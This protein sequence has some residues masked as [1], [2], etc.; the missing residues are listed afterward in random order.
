[1]RGKHDYK[2]TSSV[3]AGFVRRQGVY[4]LFVAF[5]SISLLTRHQ[6]NNETLVRIYGRISQ[7]ELNLFKKMFSQ[8]TF[9]S[10]E[11]IV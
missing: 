2:A 8:K 9:N 7:E 1:M 4:S 5:D 6:R 11:V 10:K 3:P